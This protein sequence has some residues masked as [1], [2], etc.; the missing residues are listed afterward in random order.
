MLAAR[1]TEEG[2]MRGVRNITAAI[3]CAVLMA[4]CGSSAGGGGATVAPRSH[5][6]L[7]NFAGQ[8]PAVYQHIIWIWFENTDEQDVVSPSNGGTFTSNL[9][10]RCGLAVNYHN[11]THPSLPNYIAATSGTVQG[12]AATTDCSPSACPQSQTSIFDQVHAAGRQWHEYVESPQSP[13]GNGT[14]AFYPSLAA[15]CSSSVVTLGENSSGAMH[16]DLAAGTLPAYAF[17]LPNGSDDSG[18]PADA[19]LDEWITAITASA[20]Y[21]QGSTAILIT[22]DEGGT[23]RTPGERC[24]D[25]THANVTVY[26]GC[27]VAFIAVGPAVGQ[28]RTSGYF[29]HYSMLRTTE[30]MLGISTYLGGAAKAPSMRSALHL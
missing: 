20:T 3:A 23:N 25:S 7:C 6:A 14:A 12:D 22:W 28:T 27:Q 26:P 16:D 10:D 24:D 21:K 8:A 29:T 13:C 15:Q 18:P 30:E 11:I 9:I 17:V 4:G 5:D 19:F 1:R 2:E